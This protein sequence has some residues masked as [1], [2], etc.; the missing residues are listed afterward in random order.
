MTEASIHDQRALHALGTYPN[1]WSTM[2]GGVS[3]RTTDEKVSSLLEKAP[4]SVPGVR[5]T[6]NGHHAYL[7]GGKRRSEPTIRLFDTLVV[8]DSGD[9]H[10]KNLKAALADPFAAGVDGIRLDSAK[11]AKVLVEALADAS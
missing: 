5:T 6:G 4:T 7:Y 1:G 9:I 8:T 3:E 11:A 2:V 10:P